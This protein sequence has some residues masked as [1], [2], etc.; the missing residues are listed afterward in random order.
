[1]Q[2]RFSLVLL[3]TL[4]GYLTTFSQENKT[5]NLNTVTDSIQKSSDSIQPT[6][7]EELLPT[8]FPIT[9]RILWGQN[10]LMRN[11]D[12]FK[13]SETERDRELEIRHK[14]ITAHRYLGYATMAGML[15][16]GIVGA[17]LYNGDNSLKGAHEALAGAV[18]IGYFTTAGLAL[19]APP[20]SRN[21]PPGF[22]P[23]KLHKTLAIVHLTAM[24]AT[25]LLAD[26]AKNDSDIRALHRAA[27]Y[28]AFG[29]FALSMV[30]IH[31]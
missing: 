29:S 1:M 21:N 27:A 18:N 13:L 24:I 11:I 9:Q 22:S 4:F 8:K 3:L 5:T 16:Q 14:M 6:S 23:L 28:T 10:G 31:F 2:K 19:F 26:G 20:K 7:K 25:N 15:A 12:Y 17:K 30:V